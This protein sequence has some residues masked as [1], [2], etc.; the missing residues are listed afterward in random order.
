MI[1]QAM[2]MTCPKVEWDRTQ[3]VPMINEWQAPTEMVL[4]KKLAL[5][6][7]EEDSEYDSEATEGHQSQ[8]TA[9]RNMPRQ[10]FDIIWEGTCEG[11]RA[12]IREKP[13]YLNSQDAE[14]ATPLVLAAKFHHADMVQF[15]ADEPMT[16]ARITTHE[17]RTVLHFLHS[18]EMDFNTK[19]IPLLVGKHANIHHQ[20]LSGSPATEGTIFSSGIRCCSILNAIMHGNIGLLETLLTASHQEKASSPCR[21]CELG[22]NFRRILAVALSIFQAEG[23]QCLI[24]HIKEYRKNQPID[25]DKIRVWAGQ[26][27]VH[28]HEVP[29]KSVVIE[30]SDLPESFFRAINYGSKYANALQKTIDLLLWITP[31]DEGLETMVY[32]MLT[33]AVKSNSVDAVQILLQ[34]AKQQGFR[35]RWW[36][37]GPLDDSPLMLS[38]SYGFRDIYTI[39]LKEDPSILQDYV[40]VTCWEP[41]CKHYPTKKARLFAAVLGKPMPEVKRNDW[42]HRLNVVQRAIWVFVKANHQDKF[43]L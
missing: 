40:D 35:K 43:F 36:L 38:I 16:D 4:A 39:L 3:P 25:F 14:G 20:A 18:F 24:R 13:E 29:F 32:S 19:L 22:S 42:K 17:G 8:N 34:Q 10:L 5:E 37:Q 6:D 26:D 27:L 12:Y 1:H 2:A 33:S 15:L 28:L 9:P 31:N 7:N 30:A 41:L 21:I 23:A 11:L